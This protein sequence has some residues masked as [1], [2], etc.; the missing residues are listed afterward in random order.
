MIDKISL[1]NKLHRLEPMNNANVPTWVWQVIE[2]QREA[3][4]DQCR[5]WEN[6]LCN[7]HGQIRSG[8]NCCDRWEEFTNDKNR[9]D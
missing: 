1:L 2:G 5:W 7:W 6:Y 3:R 8:E 4:C 9:G